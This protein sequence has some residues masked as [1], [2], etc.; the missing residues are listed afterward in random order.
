MGLGYKGIDE[1][2]GALSLRSSALIRRTVDSLFWWE[3][4][5]VSRTIADPHALA[6]S[7]PPSPNPYTQPDA[8]P[9]SHS[10]PGSGSQ[11]YIG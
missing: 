1:Q 5:P 10:Y 6:H 2:A 7:Q 8:N 3:L 9:T 11:D 4:H